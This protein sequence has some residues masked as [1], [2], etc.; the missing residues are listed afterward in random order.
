LGLGLDETA[1]H[2]HGQ[3]HVAQV[4]VWVRVRDRVRV[5]RHQHG[6]R[7]VDHV[8]A[9]GA[10]GEVENEADAGADDEGDERGR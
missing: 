9:C 10:E 4:R 6:Q 1:R 5:A 7:H 8:A 3:W 2:Q